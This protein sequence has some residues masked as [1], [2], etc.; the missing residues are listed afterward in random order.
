MLGGRGPLRALADRSSHCSHRGEG[1]G[2]QVR[3]QRTGAGE[4]ADGW[5]GMSLGVLVNFLWGGAPLPA[6]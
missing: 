5:A 1:G 3:V 4:S 2:A 6:G